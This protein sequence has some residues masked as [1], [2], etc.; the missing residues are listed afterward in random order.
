MA[1]TKT[2]K[3]SKLRF[4][5]LILP[6]AVIGFIIYA[7][8]VNSAYTG[9]DYGKSNMLDPGQKGV[10]VLNY[11]GADGMPESE[12]TEFT[13]YEEIELPEVTKNGYD[14]VGW[15]CSGGFCGTNL[16]LNSRE[17]VNAYAQFEKDRGSIT[18]PAALYTGELEYR[19]FSEG[20]YPSVNIE[21]ADVFVDGGF[22]LIIYPEENFNGEAKTVAYKGSFKGTVGSMKVERVETTG[23]ETGALT[24]G[25]KAEL[26]KTFAP[27]IWWARGEEYFASTVENAAENMERVLT[28][29]GYTYR[30]AQLDGPDYKCDYLYGSADNCKAYSFAVEKEEKYLDLS[31]YVFTPYNKS[32]V[33]FGMEF[34]NHI[35]DWEHITVRLMK[36]EEKGKAYC[37]PIIVEFSAH[38]FRN[39]YPWTDVSVVDGTHPEVYTALGSHGMWKDGG[40]H[41]YADA[42]IAKLTDEC[43]RG[44]EWDLWK[45]DSLETYSYDPFTLTGKGIGNS[46]WNSCFDTDYY[47]ENSNSVTNWGNRGWYPPVMLYPKLQGG[48]RGPQSQPV[49]YNPYLLNE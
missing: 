46:V 25:K 45:N 36:Y 1:K 21:A 43:S 29:R 37:R 24:D 13:A 48:P 41:V 12:E 11:N 22:K 39:F 38:S 42:K 4:L 49:L 33:V 19:E 20:D 23:I 10:L 2:K 26:L 5:W 16:T 17:P 3:K 28:D 40:S 15:Y 14:F 7:F 32:K 30:I 27:R 34:G 44:T 31:Y 8:S 35:G 47:N 18:E 9:D 6:A